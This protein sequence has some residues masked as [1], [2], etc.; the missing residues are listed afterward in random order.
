METLVKFYQ[1]TPSYIPEDSALHRS[2]DP[3]SHIKG[4][5]L[6]VLN[7]AHNMKTYCGVSV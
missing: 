2:E 3:K 5:V 4:K 6:P 1:I 7:K